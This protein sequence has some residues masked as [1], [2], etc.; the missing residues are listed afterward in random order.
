MMAKRPPSQAFDHPHLPERLAAI[1]LLRHE[2][3]G[4]TLQLPL[5]AGPRQMRVAHV[6][7]EV[8]A[9][10]VHPDRMVE[11]RHAGEPLPVARHPVDAGLHQALAR[12]RCRSRRPRSASGPASKMATAPM[13]MWQFAVLEL[14]E[15]LVQRGEA[16]VMT[17]G[18]VE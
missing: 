11:D 16:L 8:E 12:G 13:C 7:G 4:E 10:V 15:A 2:A 17:E 18:H 14:E 6:V 9:R 5:V 3:A 1:E